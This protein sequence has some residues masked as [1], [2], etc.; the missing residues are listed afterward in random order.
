[1][2]AVLFEM[3]L[4]TYAD[5]VHVC[6]TA[7]KRQY[8][9]ITQNTAKSIKQGLVVIFLNALKQQNLEG[10]GKERRVGNDRRPFLSLLFS[11]PLLIFASLVH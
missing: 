6:R 10:E 9:L 1:M 7:H 3:L 8:L 5:S 4:Q 11:F 2:L